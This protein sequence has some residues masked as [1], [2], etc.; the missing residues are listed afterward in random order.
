MQKWRV[1]KKSPEAVIVETRKNHIIA[2]IRNKMGLLV[3][4]V[5]PNSGTTN[6]G[7][8]AR[9]DSNRKTFA[10][11]LGIEE[12]LVEDLHTILV[13]LSSELEIDSQKFR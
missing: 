7:N 5:R 13:A 8:T 10:V 4:V 2:E 3:D 1:T 11:I 9:T 6:D 12:W